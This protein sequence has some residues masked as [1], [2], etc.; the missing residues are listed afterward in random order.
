MV[1]ITPL[2]YP[3]KLKGLTLKATERHVM[4]SIN[5]E[6]SDVFKRLFS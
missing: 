3:D 5:E 6:F 1:A 4:A 2:G